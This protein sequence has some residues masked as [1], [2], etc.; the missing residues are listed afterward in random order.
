MD[1]RRLSNGV[2]I[3]V[4]GMGGWAQKERQILDAFEI[5][6]RLIDTAAQYGNEA[7]VGNAI[8]HSH[9]PRSDIFVTTKLWTE[10]VRNGTVEQALEE[11]LRKLQLDYVDLYLIHWPA[12]GFEKAWDAIGRLYERQR[13][14]AAGVSNF[15]IHHLER[16]R[17][18]NR[19]LPTVNQI[20]EHPYFTNENVVDY[21]RKHQIAVEAWCPLGGPGSRSMEDPVILE[22]AHDHGKSPAQIIIRWQLQRG[23]IVIPKSSSKEHM[24][25]NFDVFNFELEE[26][27][28]VRIT[29]LNR[30]GRIGADPDHFNF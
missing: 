22:I 25:I 21:C 8:K 20:E 29:E 2:E 17:Q 4:L 27:E 26:R 11:S 24:R 19:I 18:Y 28:M 5:G 13:I 7:E 30:N 9:I 15:Q 23:I 16:I 10:D 6:Y 12:E 1:Y 3:P 14:R